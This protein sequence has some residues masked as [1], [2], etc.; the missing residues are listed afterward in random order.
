MSPE[1]ATSKHAEIGPATDVYSLGGILYFLL[2]GQPP[3]KGNSISEVLCQVVMQPPA[4]P[5]QV[6]PQ[7]PTKLGAICLRC[8]EKDP[9]KRY[10][11]AEALAAALR[12][13]TSEFEAPAPGSI[14]PDPTKRT[15]TRRIW[16]GP[17]L[18]ALLGI[19]VGL[20]LT[21]PSWMKWSATIFPPANKSGT[22]ELTA[23]SPPENLRTDFRLGVAMLADATQDALQPGEDGLI[24][25]RAGTKVKFG[26]KVAQDAY[27]GIWSVNADGT[28]EQLFPNAEEPDH[29][30]HENEVKVVPKTNAVAVLSKANG[31]DWV[32]VQASTE[33]W[34]PDEGRRKGPFLLFETLQERD[35]WAQRRRGITLDFG[36]KLSEAV[37][38][39]RVEP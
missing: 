11:S 17:A 13:P 24:R 10:P 15:R 38:T 4:A 31:K 32:W 6:N 5:Q 22:E 23:L 33:P 16:V 28:V 30:F 35:Q 25:L 9:A 3:F 34:K 37:L 19:A 29:R 20:W 2:T 7:V 36:V 14:A 26:I 12:A 18:V 39:F 21:A 1:Q 8:L 27:V